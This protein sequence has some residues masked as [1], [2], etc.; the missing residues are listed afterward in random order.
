ML[1]KYEKADIRRYIERRVSYRDIGEYLSEKL[2][3]ESEQLLQ[4]KEELRSYEAVEQVLKRYDSEWLS[5]EVDRY[6][7]IKVKEWRKF[8]LRK[9]LQSLLH[10]GLLLFISI[11]LASF[12]SLQYLTP[13]FINILAGVFLTGFF[14]Y[15]IYWIY[16]TQ[17]GLPT[18]QFRTLDRKSFI[19]AHNTIFIIIWVGPFLI[20]DLINVFFI[21]WNYAI[22]NTTDLLSIIVF[23]LAITLLYISWH[24]YTSLLPSDNIKQKQAYLSK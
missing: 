3:H 20:L 10:P 16:H 22:Q 24:S 1:S 15:F 6:E 11:G 21:D 18:E 17:G 9:L 12:F 14:G 2:I 8:L 7:K 5:K 19:K 23:S 4:G 13:N